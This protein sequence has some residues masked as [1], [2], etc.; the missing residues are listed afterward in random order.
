[1]PQAIDFWLLVCYNET[2][3]SGG[4]FMKTK[5]KLF[6]VISG[7]LLLITM[8]FDFR[9]LL[10][11]AE[12]GLLSSMSGRLSLISFL[13]NI[14]LVIF[15]FLNQKKYAMFAYVV[16]VLIQLSYVVFGF[17]LYNLVSFLREGVMLLL[18]LSSTVLS[19]K[20]E[21][22]ITKNFWFIPGALCVINMIFI[23]MGSYSFALPNVILGLVNVLFYF[24][25]GWWAAD[26]NAPAE[27]ASEA[28]G[29]C[30]AASS[31]YYNLVA[32]VLLL[33]FTFGI[34]QWIWIYRTTSYLNTPEEVYQNPTTKLLLCMF[35][36]FYFIYWTYQSAQRIDRLS[37]RKGKPSDISVICLV[38]AFF[39]EIVPP[40]LMQE[41]INSLES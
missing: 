16:K 33:L 9:F 28:S 39:V 27:E 11:Y 10:V 14:P 7:I 26:W 3:N 15:L 5:N 32:H 22:K 12:H 19:G 38:L 18:L 21:L 20:T 41:K 17:S 24:A 34:W 25:I 13:V 35:V 8:L 6:G 37:H 31:G 29:A 1:M 36:P 2:N 40:I 4:G 23:L 30:K